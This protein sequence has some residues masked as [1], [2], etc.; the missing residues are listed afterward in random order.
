M[1]EQK[2]E[3]KEVNGSV[4]VV[5]NNYSEIL[6]L[7]NNRNPQKL[8]LPGGGIEM[9]EL[10]ING[11]IREVH[12]ETGILISPC[13][14]LWVGNFVF[15]ERYGIVHLFEYRHTLA[16]VL[17]E[18]TSHEVA[19]KKWMSVPE[20]LVL[21]RSETYP[22]QQALITHYARWIRNGKQGV[23]TDYLSAPFET[24]EEYSLPART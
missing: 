23:V 18:H 19:E 6:M 10:P 22:A 15:R 5:K 7:L 3:I 21:P 24:L 16:R 13:D 8:E 17:P 9:G 11:A 20:I 2:K 4:V 12:Q 1:G 14:L